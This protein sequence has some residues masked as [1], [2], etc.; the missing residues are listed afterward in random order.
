MRLWEHVS[1][2]QQRFPTKLV[3]YSLSHQAKQSHNPNKP[4][5][6]Y[7]VLCRLE[8]ENQKSCNQL[9]KNSHYLWGGFGLKAGITSSMAFIALVFNFHAVL[10]SVRVLTHI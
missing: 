1:D 5:C 8:K 9:F 4:M 7:S 2:T 6:L 10:F 3:Q